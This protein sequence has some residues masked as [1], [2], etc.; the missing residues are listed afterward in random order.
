MALAGGASAQGGASPARLL[1][2]PGL[3]FGPNAYP[4]DA[5]AAREQGRVVAR[6]AIDA[7][8]RVSACTVAT[9]S[10]SAALDAATCRIATTRLSFAAARDGR[11]EGV[12][13]SYLLPIRWVLPQ[14]SGEPLVSLAMT[15]VATIGPDRKVGDCTGSI[16]GRRIS[17]TPESCAGYPAL[18]ERVFA[19][20]PGGIVVRVERRQ[21]YAGSALP[22][23]EE[24]GGTVLERTTVGFVIDAAGRPSG[25]RSSR[26]ARDVFLPAADPCLSR[27][28]F[29]AAG[30][31]RSAFPVAATWTTTLSYTR[32]TP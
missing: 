24:P 27:T 14:A 30:S 31:G 4:P 11:G 25:C 26:Q 17:V 5:V 22:P 19:T 12:A 8:G 18:L 9:S 21:V 32:V 16:N 20:A 2:D 29:A 6:L 10:G 7:Q 15:L 28:Q 1:G 13:A 23:I 3:F